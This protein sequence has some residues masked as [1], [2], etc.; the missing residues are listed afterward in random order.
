MTAMCAPMMSVTVREHVHI[1][2]IAIP[3]M[4]AFS[5]TVPTPAVEEPA[6]ST[7]ETPVLGP[8]ATPVRKQPTAVLT[9]RARRVPMTA[10][11]V[12]MMSV[13]GPAYVHIPTT[14]IPVMTVSSVRR[15][16]SVKVASAWE[17]MI[18]ALMMETS[19]MAWSIVRKTWEVFCVML[20]EIP[21]ICCSPVMK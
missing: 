3:A 1:P 11:S 4:T 9:P 6:L 15:P 8:S 2:T 19:V 16:M 10:M 18:P 5:V 20:Q 13:M 21:A 17:A 12:P 14:A 7:R